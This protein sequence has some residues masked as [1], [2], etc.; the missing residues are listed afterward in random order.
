MPGSRS[1]VTGDPS[2]TSLGAL[3]SMS[4]MALA[5]LRDGQS[6][7]L[8]TLLND[9]PTLI[10]SLLNKDISMPDRN[11]DSSVDVYLRHLANN[12]VAYANFHSALRVGEYPANWHRWSSD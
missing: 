6:D 7:G 5:Q 2:I 9:M 11:G 4:L 3:H 10:S 1:Y 12:D 8:E